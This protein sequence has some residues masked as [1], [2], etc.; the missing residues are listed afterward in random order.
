MVHHRPTEGRGTPT[1]KT[2]T[3]LGFWPKHAVTDTVLES[4][5]AWVAANR[6]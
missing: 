5:D 1:S 6:N 3:V 4:I 2:G